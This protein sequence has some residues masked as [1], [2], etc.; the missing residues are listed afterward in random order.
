MANPLEK[1]LNFRKLG[2]WHPKVNSVLGIDIG[3]SSVKVVQLRRSKG[4]AILETYGEISTGPYREMSV[5]QA[6]V[7]P[8]DKLTEL[9]RDLFR[10]ANVT[11]KTVSFSIPVGSSLLVIIE[12]PKVSDDMLGKMVPLEA[13]KYI[14]V[15]I[16]EVAI[17]WWVIP[18]QQIRPEAEE[19]KLEVLVVAIHNS[20]VNQ[21]QELAKLLTVEP[22][23][24]EIETFSALR[25]VFGGEMAATA[26]LD[27]GAGT[28]K[29]AIVDYGIVRLSHTINKGSQDITLA[30]ERALGVDFAKAEEIKRRVGLV[31]R[32]SGED[33]APTVSG[34]MEFI[35][36]EVNQV[37]AA[38]QDKYRR[39]VNKIMF[40]GGGALLKGVLPLAER[41]FEVPVTLGQPFEKVEAPAF[42][43]NILREAGPGFSVAIGLA[44]RHLQSIE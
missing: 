19:T 12:I 1:F 22:A 42:L 31:E 34:I 17:D 39:T 41:N 27:L 3:S 25:S 16:S 13:R 11:T 29:M 43:Q 40:I 8:P 36:N 4:K 33:L 23:F 26:I 20:V 30:I 14:P 10:E 9:L 37:I 44:L 21:Y 24:F 15:P 5:G 2:L 28:T 38:Y 6:A 32:V 35:F 18:N 7:L